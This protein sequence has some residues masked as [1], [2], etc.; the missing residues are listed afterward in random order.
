MWIRITHMEVRGTANLLTPTRVRLACAQSAR[1]H[2]LQAFN[3]L[4]S[5]HAHRCRTALTVPKFQ[6]GPTF[7][8]HGFLKKHHFRVAL[9]PRVRH[10]CNVVSAFK[11]LPQTFPKVIQTHGWDPRVL[12]LVRLPEKRRSFPVDVVVVERSVWR[13]GQGPRAPVDLSST[14]LI[15]A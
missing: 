5:T 15:L 2:A 14:V 12:A 13:Q 9:L 4:I 1:S 7:D 8:V 6:A 10:A 3:H 11:L